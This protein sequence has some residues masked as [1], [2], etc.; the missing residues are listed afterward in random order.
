MKKTQTSIDT[1][2]AYSL[3]EAIALLPTLNKSKFVGNVDVDVVLNLTEK[4]KKE[5]IRGSV[6]FP[7]MFGTPKRVAV[8]AD[9]RDAVT[10]KAAGADEAGLAELVKKL[11]AGNIDFDVIIATPSVM[12]QIARLGRI[13]GPRGLMPNPANETVTT[14]LERIITTYKRGKFDFKVGDQAVIRAKVAKVDMPAEEIKANVIALLKSIYQET[15]KLNSQPF[16]RITLSPTMGAGV[17]LD[18]NEA[19]SQ[20]A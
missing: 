18:A 6:I 15:K 10:A 3:D 20:L 2:K 14:D 11:E 12:P 17:R 5:S 16:K 7:F 13:L 4:Q 9:E 19:I 8:I 1:T